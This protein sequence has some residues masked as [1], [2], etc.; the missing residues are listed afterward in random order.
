MPRAAANTNPLVLNPDSEFDAV[1][2]ELKRMHDKKSKTYGTD[3]DPFNNF[4][5]GAQRLH[6]SPLDV[7]I[8][9]ATKH[10]SALRKWLDKETREP[11]TASNDAMIDRA[12]YAVI[13]L[14]LY[15]RGD[16]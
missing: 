4:Y 8:A 3:E 16:Y 13:Q 11:N 9:Y 14:V 1:L 15:R 5:D 7:A 12:V 6:T 10:D 2:I